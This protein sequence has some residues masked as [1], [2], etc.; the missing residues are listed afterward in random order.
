MNVTMG[1][2]YSSTQDKE[3]LWRGNLLANGPLEGQERDARLALR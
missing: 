3:Q 1:W 2:P